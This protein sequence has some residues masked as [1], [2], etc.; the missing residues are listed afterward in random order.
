MFLLGQQLGKYQIL[1]TLGS[2][3]FGTVY[4]VK[5]TWIDKRLA[6]KVPHKQG[7]DFD[8]LLHEPRLLAAMDHENI[9]RIV[10]AE[11]ADDYFFIVMEYVEGETLEAILEQD[12]KLAV[13]RA[14]EITRK[15]ACGVDYAHRQGVL[16][17]DLRPGNVLVTEKGQIKIADFGTSR[18]L[19]VAARA[20]TI[21][22]SPPYMAPEQFQGRAVFASD[23]YS[24]GVIMYEMMT[25]KLPYF[26]VNPRQLEKMALSGRLVRPREANRAIPREIEEIILK[27]LAPEIPDRYQQASQLLDDLSTASEIDH[28][29]TR[30]EDIRQRLKARERVTAGFCW[31]C[32]KPLHPRATTCPFCGEKQ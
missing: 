17:R 23:V 9:V 28:R 8:D 30:M 1:K 22:G 2:G 29:A 5:D 6:I 7:G 18:F 13:P 10:T 26:S 19:E 25:G 24:I 16:H 4:L 11:K 32:R 31:H 20:S 21:I 14:V 15:I 27:A 3:G 12:K